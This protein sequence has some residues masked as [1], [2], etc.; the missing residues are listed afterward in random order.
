M[1]HKAEKDE[2]LS[3]YRKLKGKLEKKTSN[4]IT[5]FQPK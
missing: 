2:R 4:F 5:G 1:K 3:E